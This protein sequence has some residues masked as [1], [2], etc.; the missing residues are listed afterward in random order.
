MQSPSASSEEHANHSIE[1]C[2]LTRDSEVVALASVAA[3]KAGATCIVGAGCTRCDMPCKPIVAVDLADSDYL[4][5]ARI[6]RSRGGARV[7]IAIATDTQA[8][9][10]AQDHGFRFI[11]YRALIE[12]FLPTVLRIAASLTFS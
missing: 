4:Q 8:T 10:E 1:F 5:S 11:V 7:L 6:A 12:R 2:L 3:A 9:K